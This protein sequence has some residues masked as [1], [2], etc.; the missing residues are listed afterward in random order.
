MQ[1]K[2]G[3]LNQGWLSLQI[4]A[5][6]IFQRKVLSGQRAVKSA[7]QEYK[8]LGPLL[9][10]RKEERLIPQS[11]PTLII[12]FAFLSLLQ[13]RNAI[14]PTSLRNVVWPTSV[15]DYSVRFCGVSLRLVMSP[16]DWLGLFSPQ[17]PQQRAHVNCSSTVG[18]KVSMSAH[19]HLWHTSHMHT[20][21]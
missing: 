21:M 14:L 10:C 11:W 6:E 7:F 20:P 17:N 13:L 1:G 4:T 8:L 12:M 3:P 18:W 19:S 16:Q 5:E 9:F 2:T 15:A